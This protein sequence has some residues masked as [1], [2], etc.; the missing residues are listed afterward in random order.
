[1][2]ADLLPMYWRICE[3][4]NACTI[5]GI[6][7]DVGWRTLGFATEPPAAT[8]TEPSPAAAR[9]MGRVVDSPDGAI[10][11]IRVHVS[12]AVSENPRAPLRQVLGSEFVRI[13]PTWSER[14][15]EINPE[16]QAQ[17]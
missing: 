8:T 2:T 9:I 13:L 17:P 1:M 15:L 4:T 7:L 14:L 10:V 11:A 16:Y 5:N 3:V 12:D 6:Q